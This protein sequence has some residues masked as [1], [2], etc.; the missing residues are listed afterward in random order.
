MVPSLGSQKSQSGG[1]CL[2]PPPGHFGV[3]AAV[4]CGIADIAGTR[5]HGI[6]VAGSWGGGGSSAVGG[7]SDTTCKSGHNHFV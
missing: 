6:C 2:S 4:L 7:S 3:P 5:L 1:P